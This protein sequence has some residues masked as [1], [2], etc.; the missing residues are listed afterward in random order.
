VA[1][2]Y[3]TVASLPAQRFS[4]KSF[5]TQ[6][7]FLEYCRIEV[8]PDDIAVIEAARI[9]YGE[10]DTTA[11]A[12]TSESGSAA[13]AGG[14]KAVAGNALLTAWKK[15]LLDIQRQAALAR[16]QLLG[17]DADDIPRVDLTDV[18]LP[19]QVRQILNEDNPLK[20][21]I[22]LL[23]ILW[24]QADVLE[25]GHHFDCEK[26]IVYHLKL[27]IA[28]RR[29]RINDVEAGREEFDRQYD[30]AAQSLMEITP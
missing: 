9:W 4:E 3:Y 22:A 10:S 28:A 14:G 20:T 1:Q 30:T 13:S 11:S 16:A 21:E 8:S 17:R 29:A 19:E 27:Q 2:Y 24:H 23:R 15:R 25:A 26:L 12:S 5:L 18:G 6:E 7:E